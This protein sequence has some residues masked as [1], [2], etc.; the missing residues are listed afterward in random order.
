[1]YYSKLKD[2]YYKHISYGQETAFYGLL[3]LPVAITGILVMTIEYVSFQNS[4][5]SLI[6]KAF[7]II[8][9]ITGVHLIDVVNQRHA[10][11]NMISKIMSNRATSKKIFK[12][13]NRAG[14]SNILKY[15]GSC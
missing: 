8:S 10:E 12:V 11:T 6:Y 4:L 3:T 9:G 13:Q 5:T 1:V 2:Y 14:M 15:L 7:V